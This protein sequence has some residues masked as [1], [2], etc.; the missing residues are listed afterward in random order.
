M[1]MRGENED[2]TNTA[3]DQLS[4]ALEDNLPAL[5][6][7][8]ATSL[9]NLKLLRTARAEGLRSEHE[10]LSA[11]LG[12]DH[13]R[14]AA[15]AGM[16]ADNDEFINAV[17]VE[18]ERARVEVPQADAQTW[19]LHGFIRDLRSRGVP[20]VTVALYDASGNFARQLGFA[21]TSANGYFRLKSH[22]LEKLKPV[23]IH[24][25]N[26]QGAHLHTDN[27]PLTPAAGSV[28]YHEV[29][30]TGTQTGPPPGDC[31]PDPVAEPGV[32]TVRGRVADKAGKG[33]SGLIVSLFD[34]DL[35]FDDRLSQTETDASGNFSLAYR[36]EDFRDLI[37]RKPDIYLKVI[38]QKGKT[39]F[40]SKKKVRFEAG[41]VEI[42]NVE[43]GE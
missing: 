10:R 9:D 30:I 36:T 40:S 20:N 7:M 39:L 33:L 31:R 26:S 35:L 17:A 11:K 15:L 6:L 16:R 23:F 2:S 24:V 22:S 32:W 13:P 27:V 29:V 3:S 21:T 43:I 42:V 41:R 8:R 18:A 34:K 4:Q 12:A 25:L 28:V 37:E 1:N 38:D 14:V 19:V 5:D